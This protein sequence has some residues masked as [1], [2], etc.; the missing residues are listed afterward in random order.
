M[1]RAYIE[2]PTFN[3]PLSFADASCTTPLIFVL[4]PGADPM[5]ALLKFAEDRG[6]GGSKV[7]SISLG[8]GQVWSNVYLR[9]L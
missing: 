8:Q 2:P 4:S 9:F 7:Q 3:L 1:G 6:F 5:A